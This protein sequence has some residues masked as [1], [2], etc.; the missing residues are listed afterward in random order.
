[1][2]QPV[3]TAPARRE[4]SYRESF[5]QGRR[6][7]S[8]KAKASSIW[9]PHPSHTQQPPPAQ[10]LQRGRCFQG[11][12]HIRQWT[13]AKPHKPSTTCA[14]KRAAV[15]AAPGGCCA[16][17]NFFQM[18]G[19]FHQASADEPPPST[20]IHIQSPCK[21]GLFALHSLCSLAAQGKQSTRPKRRSALP[22][23]PS[24]PHQCEM[25]RSYSQITEK[26]FRD[27]TFPK[28]KS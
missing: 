2:G 4:G 13:A 17:V 18:L 12:F 10:L 6:G 7:E 8:T 5:L 3:W 20:S 26:R 22:E 21:E 19:A 23:R 15:A 28:P 25:A 27:Q 24:S 11:L 16:A 9:R 1:M 14:N